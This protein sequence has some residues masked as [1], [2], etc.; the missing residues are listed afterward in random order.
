MGLAR[1]IMCVAA[2]LREFGAHPAQCSSHLRVGGD[3]TEEHRLQVQAVDGVPHV[4]DML[5]ND[6]LDRLGFVS[7]GDV[8]GI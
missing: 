6:S 2:K 3:F 1:W 5:A 8:R 7:Q 4:V